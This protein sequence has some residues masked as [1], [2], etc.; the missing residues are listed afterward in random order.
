MDDKD[1]SSKIGAWGAAAFTGMLGALGLFGYLSRHGR[2]PLA[3]TLDRLQDHQKR[4]S[5]ARDDAAWACTRAGEFLRQS[6]LVE[7]EADRQA[8]LRPR[9]RTRPWRTTRSPRAARTP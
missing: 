5:H 8:F 3:T 7:I 6:L 2:D 9:S 4:S 1:L